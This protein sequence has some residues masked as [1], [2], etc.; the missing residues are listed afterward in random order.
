MAN[1]LAKETEVIVPY[2]S[3]VSPLLQHYSW[4]NPTDVV[5]KIH[6]KKKIAYPTGE[7]FSQAIVLERSGD[8]DNYL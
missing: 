5:T 6:W 8:M 3:E 2:Q 4:N 7:E 1:F